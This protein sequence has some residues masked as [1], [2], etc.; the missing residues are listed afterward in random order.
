VLIA[1]VVACHYWRHFHGPLPPTEIY[2]GLTYECVSLPESFESGGLLHLIR[3][4]L[5][6][7]GVSLFL[8]PLDREVVAR[9]WQYKLEFVSTVVDS[10]RLAAAVNATLFASQSTLIRRRGDLARSNETVVADHIVSHIHRDSYLMWWDDE[11]VA[12][13]ETTKPPSEAALQRAKWGIGGQFGLIVDGKVRAA[14][15]DLVDK[16]TVIAAEPSNHLVWIAVF[17]RASYHFAG[18]ALVDRGA[19]MG[20][21]VDGGTSSTMAVGPTA[22]HIVVGTVSG[23]WRPV[24]TVFGFRADPLTPN[25]AP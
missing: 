11:N 24:A 19:T 14:V 10:Q 16:R 3:A 2:H 6:V 5:T 4:D 7:P 15:D 1:A 23:D 22:S 21:M 25:L 17:D 20:I 18:Q 13:L 12:H 8:T 9:G